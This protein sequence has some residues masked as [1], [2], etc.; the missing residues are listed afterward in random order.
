LNAGGSFTILSFRTGFDDD[1]DDEEEEDSSRMG[2]K[3]MESTSKG[4]G[5]SGQL[6]CFKALS[7]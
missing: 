2:D 7:F 3:G 4:F 6:S 5:E 1:D